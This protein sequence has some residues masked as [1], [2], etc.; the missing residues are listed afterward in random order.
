MADKPMWERC[1][2]RDRLITFHLS[3]RLTLSLPGLGPVRSC[4]RRAFRHGVAEVR[5]PL[6]TTKCLE[7]FEEN[8]SWFSHSVT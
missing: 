4:L 3:T 8:L 6:L 2:R 1:K 5:V 7:D